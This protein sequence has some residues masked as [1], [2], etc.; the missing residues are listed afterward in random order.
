MQLLDRHKF[1]TCEEF[2]TIMDSLPIMVR[3]C[4]KDGTVCYSNSAWNLF[5]SD[6]AL[7][8]AGIHED[9]RPSYEE[10]FVSHAE[11]QTAFKTKYRFRDNSGAY[12]WLAEHSIPWYST[13]GTYLGCVCYMMDIDEMIAT[14]VE[15]VSLEALQREQALNEELEASNEELNLTNGELQLSQEKLRQ[16]NDN[17]EQILNMLPASV[18]VIRG[19][20][21]EV[22]MINNSNLSYWQKTKEQVLG[23][24][25]LEILPDL[26]DQPFASQLRRVMET[27][28]I[29]D[30]KESPVLFTSPDGNTRETYVDY[31]YQP[32]YDLEGNC[33][34]VLVMSFEITNRVLSRRLLEKYAEELTS[35]NA[36][37]LI[38][39]EELA[40][41]EA[42]FKYLIQEAPVA[43]GVLHE[44]DL[45]IES[46]NSKILEVWGKSPEIVGIPLSKALPELQG[47]PF[48]GIL[49]DVYTTGR[50]FYA[51]EI[52]SL[53]EHEGVLKE[54]FFNVTYQPVLDISGSTSDIMVVAV[55]VTEQ[56][57]SRR[58]VEQSEQHFRYLADLVPAKISNALPNGEVT[59]FNKQWLDFAG[60]NFEDLRDFGYHQMMH[61]E[62]IPEFQAGLAQA[63]ETGVPHVSEMRFKN[64]QGKYIWHLNIASPIL[65]EAGNI[66]MWVGSTTDIQ[67]LK[68]EAQ[69]KGDFVSMLSH[70]LKTPVT[71]IKGHVQL[72]LRA[73]N[74]ETTSE[75]TNKLSPSLS[76]I[77]KLL[78]QLTG[79]I[80]D[81]LDLT[82]I[83]SGRLDLKKESFLLEGLVMEVVEDFRLSHQQ[84][85]F[86]LDLESGIKVFAD[87]HKISQVL[88]NL[89]A[90]AIKY[91]PNS[92][93]VD[94]SLS[95]AGNEVLVRIKD[96]GIGIDEKDQKNI[97]ERFYRVEGQNESH[98]SGFGIGLYLACSIVEFHGGK[99][100]VESSKGKGSTFIV[101]LPR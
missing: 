61:P 49:D 29:I 56:V 15:Q 21:L 40:R 44:R 22:E 7:W 73:L 82:R 93:V 6:L 81:M 25:F 41:S 95:T 1:N 54:I 24:P 43:I 67:I 64:T 13:E 75:L 50:P 96:Y 8:S 53:L 14:E 85:F 12:R 35:A 78:V 59:F 18:V 30:V 28:E 26:T 80:A 74:K 62:E 19:Y 90:N 65:D 33:T 101:H 87:R 10:L 20:N 42:R 16:G 34:G 51:N 57:N 3:A 71:S 77:D 83:D 68:E 4:D 89:I 47:Q 23:R 86:H 79:L 70:E 11:S 52:R 63:A 38:S 27:G 55:D 72:L 98:Y 66:K 32:L 36:R 46:A 2:R 31:T 94:I 84:H 97:F 58:Q 17:L 45:I 69:R 88:I 5:T 92:N 99:I 9:F 100:T 48:L 37:L 39:N 60:M 76:R 91:G